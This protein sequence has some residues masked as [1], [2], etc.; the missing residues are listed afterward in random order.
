MATHRLGVDGMAGVEEH[1][2]MVDG[3]RIML[4]IVGV[5]ETV[6]GIWV[7]EVARDR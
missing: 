4:C 6:A 1:C 7:S 3:V 5:E 2:F